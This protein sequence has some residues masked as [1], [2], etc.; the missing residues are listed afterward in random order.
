MYG[1]TP[2]FRKLFLVDFQF[3]SFLLTKHFPQ[4]GFS[5]LLTVAMLCACQQWTLASR[6]V[7]Q[8]MFI[9]KLFQCGR[10]NIFSGHRQTETQ[11]KPLDRRNGEG[12]HCCHSLVRVLLHRR[13]VFNLVVSWKFLQV[14][15][16]LK[17]LKIHSLWKSIAFK[18]NWNYVR[19]FVTSRVFLW[20]YLK[21]SCS[22]RCH[23]A[24]ATMSMKSVSFR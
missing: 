14:L 5:Q 1:R 3:S 6:R 17:N 9:R 23:N 19:I 15:D 22:N 11:K 21:T 18:K 16:T 8:S 4:F 12:P 13:L 24:T 2:Q 10:E 7:C 20:R